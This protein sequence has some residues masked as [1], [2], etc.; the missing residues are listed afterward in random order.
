MRD[1]FFAFGSNTKNVWYQMKWEQAGLFQRGQKK[2]QNEVEK[3]NRI[4]NGFD[5]NRKFVIG[6]QH[7][8][9]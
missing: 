4:P 3:K 5:L 7:K 8:L 6:S 9:Q 1:F 2:E